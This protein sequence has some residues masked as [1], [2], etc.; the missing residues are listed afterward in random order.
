LKLL[1]KV[2][3]SSITGVLASRAVM[4]LAKVDENNAAALNAVFLSL[5]GL[6]VRENNEY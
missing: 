1:K 5:E 4:V 3:I 2:N 6:F